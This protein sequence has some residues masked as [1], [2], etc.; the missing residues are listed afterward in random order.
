MKLTRREFGQQV[1]AA[2]VLTPLT[3][4]S[5][6]AAQSGSVVAGVR[7]GA[8]TY[9]FR[10]RPLEQVPAALKTAGLSFAELWSGHVESDSRIGID[11]GT[12]REARRE[13]LRAWRT[14]VPLASFRDIRT[15][16]AD[17]GVTLTSYDIPYRDDWTDDEIVRSFAMADALGVKVITSSAVLS[18]VPRLAKLVERT[19]LSIAFHNH[20]VIRANE[21]ATPGDLTSAMRASPK[22]GVTLDI[23]HFTAANFDAV[24]FLEEHH[25]RVHALHVKDRKKDQGD[26]MPLG[27]GDA[28]VTE[29]LRLLR[30]RNWDIPAHIEFDYR[31]ADPAAEAAAGYAYCRRLLEAR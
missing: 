29:V 18:V 7:I 19:D 27:Q 8:Q 21:F 2:T 24:K 14:T 28:P 15:A 25:A 4:T 17:S 13:R 23:G 5:R 30:D 26:G 10:G 12:P 3:M 9:I 11:A 1:L 20:S 31:P 6:T 22:I 16:F